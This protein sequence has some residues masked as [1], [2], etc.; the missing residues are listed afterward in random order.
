MRHTRLWTAAA[1][2]VVVT[3][4]GCALA[5]GRDKPD[6]KAPP[7]RAAAREPLPDAVEDVQT[8]REVEVRRPEQKKTEH[9]QS[10][11]FDPAKA[12]KSSP[13]LDTQPE[14]G[15]LRGFDFARDP[16]NAKEPMQSPADIMKQDIADKPK[17]MDAHRKLLET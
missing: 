10:D 12:P 3:A 7:P 15:E 6:A 2:G 5:R 9:D 14:K 8:P 13:V 1:V 4:V 17:V 16:L 11:A